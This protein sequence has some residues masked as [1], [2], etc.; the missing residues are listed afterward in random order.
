MSCNI[1]INLELIS[2]LHTNCKICSSVKHRKTFISL[3]D[4]CIYIKIITCMNMFARH[5]LVLHDLSWYWLSRS[6]QDAHHNSPL[7]TF[8]MIKYM[9][10]M[11]VLSLYI[12]IDSFSVN[13]HEI[14]S[15]I[16]VTLDMTNPTHFVFFLALPNFSY[17]AP[18]GFNGIRF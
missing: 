13:K 6:F 1:K 3:S 8:Y 5:C 14:E 4:E 7:F 9:H 10:S 17:R 18:I 15:A 12:Y 11:Y 2:Y 16:Y